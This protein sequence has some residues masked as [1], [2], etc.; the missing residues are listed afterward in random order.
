MSASV[1]FAIEITLKNCDRKNSNGIIK[2][3]SHLLLL[4]SIIIEY[5]RIIYAIFLVANCNFA[6]LLHF[7]HLKEFVFSFVC[8][9][10]N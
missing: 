3:K 8:Y 9:N 2:K 6:Q 7:I 1:K 10:E 4:V 5:Y